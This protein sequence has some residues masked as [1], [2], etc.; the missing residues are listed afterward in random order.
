MDENTRARYRAWMWR[1]LFKRVII[2]ILV[3]IL[4]LTAFILGR[5]SV[6]IPE[7]ELCLVLECPPPIECENSDVEENSD[8][9]ATYAYP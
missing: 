7:C 6:T 2:P 8:S 3:L 9:D 4:F 5:R 1:R